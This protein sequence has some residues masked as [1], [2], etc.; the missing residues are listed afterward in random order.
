MLFILEPDF[1]GVVVTVFFSLAGKFT[2]A[3]AVC[4]VIILSI[5]ISYMLSLN[6]GGVYKKKSGQS[7]VSYPYINTHVITNAHT[8]RG[9]Q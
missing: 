4:M 5:A 7:K 3:Q 6:N 1:D 9:R 2:L 8:H